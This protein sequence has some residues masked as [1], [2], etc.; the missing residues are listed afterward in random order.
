VRHFLVMRGTNGLLRSVLLFDEEEHE[1]ALRS[2]ERA[3]ERGID[4][5]LLGADSLS[6]AIRTHGVWFDE[7]PDVVPW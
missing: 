4:C 3:E 2:Y 6:T 7:A 5:V 1:L